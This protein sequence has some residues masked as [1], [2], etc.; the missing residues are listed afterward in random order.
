[1]FAVNWLNI[2]SPVVLHPEVAREI[3]DLKIEQVVLCTGKR[4]SF[5]FPVLKQINIFHM[6]ANMSINSVLFSVSIYF[7]V[8]DLFLVPKLMLIEAVSTLGWFSRLF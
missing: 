3:R 6:C 7:R 8:T 2:F 4:W 1:M 5:F